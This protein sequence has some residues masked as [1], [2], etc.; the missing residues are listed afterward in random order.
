MLVQAWQAA[1]FAPLVVRWQLFLQAAPWSSPAGVELAYDL[2][3]DDAPG[4]KQHVNQKDNEIVASHNL[5]NG[6]SP[7]KILTSLAISVVC[8][9][10]LVH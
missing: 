6:P 4:S 5:G 3:V 7:L 10:L 2:D 9:F 1:A 8:S